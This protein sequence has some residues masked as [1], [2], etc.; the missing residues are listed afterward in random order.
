LMR[1]ENGAV[2]LAAANPITL[3]QYSVDWAQS[4]MAKG[5]SHG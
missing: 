4:R 2:R 5:M 1:L 3:E